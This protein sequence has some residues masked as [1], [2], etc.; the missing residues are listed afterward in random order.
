MGLLHQAH[1]R[2]VD[3]LD[4][5]CSDLE[6]ASSATSIDASSVAT[7]D[8]SEEAS[9]THSIEGVRRPIMAGAHSDLSTSSTKD[10]RKMT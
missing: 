2:L 5:S 4:A 9:T 7:G 10:H 8:A 3:P 1:S 6:D